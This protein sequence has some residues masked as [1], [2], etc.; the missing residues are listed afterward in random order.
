MKRRDLL[1]AGLAGAF[2]LAAPSLAGPTLD[3]PPGSFCRAP[4]SGMLKVKGSASDL[5][6]QGTHILTYGALEALAEVYRGPGGGRLLVTGGGCDDGIAAVLGDRIDLGGLCCPVQGTRAEGM[7]WHQVAW[8]IK[9]AVTHPTT[10]IDSLPSEALGPL[11]RGE[12]TGWESLGADVRPVAL[13]VRRHCP[14]KFEPVRQLLLDGRPE[15]SPRSL[16]VETD[17]QLIDT[18]SRFPGAIGFVSRV[19]AQPLIANGHLKALHIDGVPPERIAV[20]TGR[21]RLKG[22]LIL[23]Y[24]A[25]NE[26]MMG[27]FFDFLASREGQDIIGRNLVPVG[28]DGVRWRDN[29]RA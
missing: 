12:I 13:V 6:Y 27:P 23:V 24:R 5:A 17:Q 25:W 20:E 29:L 1:K 28:S 3:L 8:D 16:W 10:A 2:S 7:P 26:I 18:V 9:V 21:Y 15:W 11:A 14:D 22:P 19:F 4:R